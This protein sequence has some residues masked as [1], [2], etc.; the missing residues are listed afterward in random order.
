MKNIDDV[1]EAIHI[2]LAV[3]AF[4]LNSGR[5]LKAIEICK[6]CLNFLVNE[7]PEEEENIFNFLNI[8]IYKTLFKAYFLVNDYMNAT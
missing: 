1:L 3:V 7:A 5:G 8:A 6:E 2:S 4:L